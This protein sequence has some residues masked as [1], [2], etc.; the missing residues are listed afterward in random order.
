MSA[1]VGSSKNLKDLKDIRDDSEPQLS[2]LT[3]NPVQPPTATRHGVHSD[4][5]AAAVQ[6]YGAASVPDAGLDEILLNLLTS[7]HK[8]GFSVS[9]V[10][11]QGPGSPYSSKLMSGERWPRENLY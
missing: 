5:G 3:P 6:V 1:Y 9:A 10:S 8:T 7:I 11:K 2:G 4:A